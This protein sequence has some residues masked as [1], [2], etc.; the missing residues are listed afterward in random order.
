MI[1]V[2]GLLR[3]SKKMKNR[4][5]RSPKDFPF[6]HFHAGSSLG[7]YAALVS[8]SVSYFADSDDD[9]GRQI[10]EAKLNS[11]SCGR[12]KVMTVRRLAWIVGA[13]LFIMFV[14]V[15]LSVLYIVFYSY[16]I[17]P[18]HDEGFY[19]EYA[20]AAAPYCSIVAGIP[21]FYF[22]CRWLGGRW[23]ADF[24][25]KSALLVW[26]VYALIDISIIGATAGFTVQLA[27]L[28]AISIATKFVSA[29]LGGSAA[30]GKK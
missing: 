3:R 14:N 1:Y 13:A 5:R 9:F 23:E 25:V 24:A 2:G 22:V 26:L 28:A 20:S 15:V 16:F 19:Q 6:W 4:S 11:K 17:N 30:A 27:V 29:Y 12:R 8:Y 18:G 21:L 10:A 7:L